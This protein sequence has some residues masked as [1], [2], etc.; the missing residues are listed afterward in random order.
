MGNTN[1]YIQTS[2]KIIIPTPKNNSPGRFCLLYF[3]KKTRFTVFSDFP[4]ATPLMGAKVGVQTLFK[5]SIWASCTV[6]PLSDSYLLGLSAQELKQEGNVPPWLT[7]AV[8]VQ[9]QWY[10]LS[11]SAM[12]KNNCGSAYE[13]CLQV[14]NS[15]ASRWIHKYRIQD[16]W[17]V[18]GNIPSSNTLVFLT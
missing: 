5:P 9:V 1:T 10:I 18:W 4:E 11:S 14:T 6:L 16:L 17:W 2:H 8:N 7:L 3:T 12:F 13:F 15:L